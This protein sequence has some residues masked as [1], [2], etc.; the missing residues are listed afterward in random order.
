MK[1]IFYFSLNKYW[2]LK[3]LPELILAIRRSADAIVNK[4]ILHQ[5]AEARAKQK[6]YYDWDVKN[7][8][9]FKIGDLV[10]ITNFRTRPGHSKSFEPKHIGPYR[11]ERILGRPQL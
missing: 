10:T 9:V 11:I 3:E 5:T 8:V 7:K 1:W 6:K 4:Q 2:V